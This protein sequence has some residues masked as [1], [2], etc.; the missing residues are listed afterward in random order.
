MMNI[1]TT[2]RRII[3]KVVARREFLLTLGRW[4]GLAGLSALM[5]ASGRPARPGSKLP[6]CLRDGICGQCARFAKCTLPPAEERRSA[7]PT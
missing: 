1:K 4:G 3:W 6:P 7:L 5:V 2:L